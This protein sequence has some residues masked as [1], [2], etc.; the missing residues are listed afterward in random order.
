MTFYV[1][2][3][4][5]R[6]VLTDFNFTYKSSANLPAGFVILR[7]PAGMRWLLQTE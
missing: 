3:A 6:F 7:T 1:V 4:G 2:P 5:M